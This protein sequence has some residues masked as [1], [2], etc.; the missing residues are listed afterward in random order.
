VV[1][2]ALPVSRIDRPSGS[3]ALASA[4]GAA[5]SSEAAG[6]TRPTSPMAT[7]VPFARS[8]DESAERASRGLPPP[9]AAG[10]SEIAGR[11]PA[12]TPPRSNRPLTTGGS[13]VLVR[14]IDQATL[15]SGVIRT[16]ITFECAP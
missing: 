1:L 6:E 5:G 13:S 12:T 8:S 16:D 4:L 2:R 14:R 11:A 3:A 7:A 9:Q 15:A 10:S